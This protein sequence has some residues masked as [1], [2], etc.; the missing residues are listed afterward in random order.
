LFAI[1]DTA[2]VSAVHKL[3]DEPLDHGQE[4]SVV[5]TL[6]LMRE[7]RLAVSHGL[8]SAHYFLSKSDFLSE[9][10]VVF[11]FEVNIVVTTSN[12]PAHSSEELVKHVDVEA[13]TEVPSSNEC[14]ADLLLEL[15]I[16]V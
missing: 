5:Q 9:S 16:V 8:E 15:S 2:G 10:E 4:A 6:D 12:G 14:V 1:E 11:E 3:L 13:S 7:H